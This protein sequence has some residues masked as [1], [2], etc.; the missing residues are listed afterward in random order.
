VCGIGKLSATRS[1]VFRASQI[2]NKVMH[3]C[4]RKRE[5]RKSTELELF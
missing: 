4:M 3:M 2:R 5:E 1:S